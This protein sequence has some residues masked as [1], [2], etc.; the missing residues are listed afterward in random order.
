[1]HRVVGNLHD[2]DTYFAGAPHDQYRRL[3]HE[4]PVAWHDEPNGP[5]FWTVTRH[6][7]ACAVLRDTAIY[8]S[9]KGVTLD[10]IP[11]ALLASLGHSMMLSD[12]PQ[13][14]LLRKLVASMFAPKAIA[15][16]EERVSLLLEQLVS[17]WSGGGSFDFAV[18]LAGRLPLRVI[19]SLLGV[20]LEDQEQL[21]LLS[22]RMFAEHGHGGQVQ[23][24]RFLAASELKAYARRLGQHRRSAP[25]GDIVSVLVHTEIDGQRLSDDQ[26]EALFML[27]FNAG[28]ET[29]RSLLCHLVQRLS[30]EPSLQDQL[31][32]AP[33]GLPAIIEECARLDP[34]VLQLRRTTTRPAELG[35]QTLAAGAKVMVV[36]ASANRDEAVFVDA[37]SFDPR[38][39]PNPH[40]SFGFGAHFCLGAHIARMQVRMVMQTLLRLSRRFECG[41]LRY[42]RSTF[43]RPVISL[44]LVLVP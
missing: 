34:S 30:F 36:I 40:L 38:R 20:P 1:M 8:S 28:A 7:D 18:E 16:L 19:S 21:F 31:R 17:P 4:R 22:Q 41:P 29:T 23:Q 11:P 6:A 24:A 27:L 39:S 43:V 26:F 15:S 2:A 3:R 32:L 35:G 10:E 25:T 12:P 14:T 42:E 9:A 33:E 37:D 13:H 5:G 44:P